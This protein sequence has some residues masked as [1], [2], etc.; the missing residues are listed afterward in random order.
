MSSSLSLTGHGACL[1][2]EFGG[3]GIPI[4]SVSVPGA[5]VTIGVPGRSP[6]RPRSE[7]RLADGGPGAECPLLMLDV[8]RALRPHGEPQLGWE[9]IE[10]TAL[11]H[12]LHQLA[13]WPCTAAQTPARLRAHRWAPPQAGGVPSPV[14][15]SSLWAGI[16]NQFP[17]GGHQ[18]SS[19]SLP[20]QLTINSPHTSSAKMHSTVSTPHPGSRR[21]VLG[22]AGCV[23]RPWHRGRSPGRETGE[24]RT[25]QTSLLTHR[26][27]QVHRKRLT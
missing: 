18:A 27:L 7:L 3:S 14:L 10:G 23:S 17:W 13:S 26:P 20:P 24:G 4:S 19:V 8:P 22:Q 9:E 12:P 6:G 11:T 25:A 15:R 1:A 2:P 16:Q 21:A 5:C